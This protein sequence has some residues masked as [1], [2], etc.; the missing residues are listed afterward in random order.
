MKYREGF[1]HFL[2][3]ILSLGGILYNHRRYHQRGWWGEEWY[4]D[5]TNLLIIADP[6]TYFDAKKVVNSINNYWNSR[7]SKW[8]RKII[9]IANV[10]DYI[11][12]PLSEGLNPQTTGCFLHA[13]LISSI[14]IFINGAIRLWGHFLEPKNNVEGVNVNVKDTSPP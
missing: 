2:P 1:S 9:D 8:L 14:T 11:Y 3:T 12:S 4:W 13:F 5:R 10:T 6:R 7:S